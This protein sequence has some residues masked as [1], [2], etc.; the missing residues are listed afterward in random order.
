MKKILLSILAFGL[1]FCPRSSAQ[2]YQSGND[3][4]TLKWKT[5]STT[6]FKLIYPEGLD[7]LAAVYGLKLEGYKKA[8]GR[9]IGVYPNERYRRP[10]HVTLHAQTTSANG[11][12]NWVP[13]T[14][15]LYTIPDAYDPDVLPWIDNLAIH[16]GR[17]IAQLQATRS[18]GFGVF[19]WLTGDLFGGAVSALYP[20]DYFLEGDAVVAETALTSA[21]RGRS[22]DFL[23]YYMAAFSEG[24]FRNWYR[25]RYGSFKHF[26]PDHYKLGYL[27][28]GG[29]RYAFDAPD[30][31]TKYFDN[32]HGKWF[33]F[34]FDALNKT[35]KEV[36]G[37]KLKAAWNEIAQT[38]NAIWKEEMDARG[39]FPAAERITAETKHFTEYTGSTDLNG[40]IYAIR[41]GTATSGR[42]VRIEKDGH[43][44]VIRPF[45]AVTSALMASGTDSRIYWSESIPDKRWTLKASSRIRYIET[46]SIAIKNLTKKG[47]YFNPAPSPD[48]SRIAATS[49]PMAGGTAI[50]V[51]DNVDGRE[52]HHFTAP[53]SIQVVESAWLGDHL[54]AS[55]ISD[56][57]FGIYDVSDGFSTMLK[58]Q[59]AKIK[60]LRNFNGLL[61][62]VSDRAGVNEL[63]SLEDGKVTQL[64]NNR[65]GASDFIIQSDSV[66]FSALTGTGRAV[67]KAPLSAVGKVDYSQVHLHPVAERLSEQESAMGKTVFDDDVEMSHPS[68]YNKL[69]HL[70]RI[71]SWMPVYVDVD[72][73]S[74][75]SF[76]KVM[77]DGLLGASALFQNDLGTAYGSLG[78]SLRYSQL[79]ELS[80]PHWRSS[81][82][83]RFTYTGRYP[84]VKLSADLGGYNALNYSLMAQQTSSRDV[85]SLTNRDS[86]NISARVNAQIYVP[87]NFSSG[88]WSRGIVPQISASISND[89]FNTTIVKMRYA[90]I[91]KK[92]ET[93]GAL[94][95]NGLSMGKVHPLGRVTASLRGYTMMNTAS[96]NVYPKWG[97]GAEGGL[98]MRPGLTSI[99]TP[100][101]FALI[102]GYLPGIGET[103][104]I[105]VSSLMQYQMEAPFSDQ[106]TRVLPRGYVAASDLT[107][108]ISAR[109]PMQAK[110]TVDYSLPFLNVDWAGLGRLAYLKN[111]ELRAHFDYATY[112]AS[113]SFRNG[114]LFST[115]AELTMNLGSLAWVPYDTR[116]G[117]SYSFNGGPSWADMT[118][119][120]VTLQR[121]HLGFIFSVDL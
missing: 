5:F 114:A 44:T 97:I 106:Y 102:Y 21:G 115:G 96:S 120:G 6:D 55:G 52:I 80:L 22:A 98:S 117:F 38:Q 87:L 17:H 29:A 10:I 9:S 41:R 82:H 104:G 66:I 85:L 56:S 33:P 67:Y 74:S 46:G 43:T 28:I 118:K 24:D 69:A 78:Y 16:E 11:S 42:M 112:G 31:T 2:L 64:S 101:L 70:I 76:E 40:E 94:F 111:F 4:G 23:E 26:T 75:L 47:R 90:Q 63:Y 61:T 77:Q 100:D 91:M 25:W 89:F 45:A 95:F 15:D 108:Y 57:G 86:K 99:L 60:Q 83:G 35:F 30:F 1:L 71:H 65:L 81:L 92:G 48:G 51:L 113:K 93:S 107:R 27:T 59:Q 39:P 12:V 34:G 20:S 88:G 119:N 19:N 73:V 121:H 79:D 109:Y 116:V 36:S 32:I 58:P 50:V 84:V 72:D 13:H 68:R 110:Y 8:I 53:D 18:R 62:F 49:Y 7:S 14:V 37:M 3:Q 105:R 54:V 103:H